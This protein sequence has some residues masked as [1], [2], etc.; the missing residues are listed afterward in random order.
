MRMLATLLST[1][2]ATSGL[3]MSVLAADPPKV[4]SMQDILDATPASAWRTL[5]PDNTLYLQL[6][7]GRVVIELAPDFAPAHA[8]NIRALV[9]GGYWDGLFVIRSQDNY[10][11]QWG[12]PDEGDPAVKQHRPLGEAKEKLPAEFER[13]DKGVPFVKLPDSDGWAPEVGFSGGF[14]V[15]RDPRA[16]KA[17]LTH[18]YGMVGAGRDVD[19]DSS[20]GTSLYAVIGQSPRMLDRNITV[21]GRV[22][23]GMELL[24]VLPRGTGPLGF[25]EKP[26]QYVP[27]QS[28]KLASQL[29]ENERT[30]LQLLRTDS[31]AFSELVESR[32]NR[33]DEWYKRPAGHIDL[34]NVPLPVRKPPTG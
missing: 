18:C 30:P 7:S 8:A 20:N 23:Q 16:G 27:I 34:C 26:E 3:A 31:A 33:R 2:L 1:L 29:P 11:V 24:S 5:D 13:S 19:A 14:P 6:A 9:K 10:V 15:A 21:V 17:W 25:Y 28:V 32:R 22:V 4:K 12:E